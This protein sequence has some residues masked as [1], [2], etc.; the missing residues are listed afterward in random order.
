MLVEEQGQRSRGRN[1]FEVL[2]EGRPVGL[3]GL[4]RE[5]NEMSS[6][7]QTGAMRRNLGFSPVTDT[8]FG[9]F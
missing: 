3:V 8:A 5:Q 4:G 9:R 2:K 7:R 1:K 6:E